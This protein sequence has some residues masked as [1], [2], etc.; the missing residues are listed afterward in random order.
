MHHRTSDQSRVSA[1]LQTDAK[2][3]AA[4]KATWKWAPNCASKDFHSK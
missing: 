1:L 2:L 4:I 3:K